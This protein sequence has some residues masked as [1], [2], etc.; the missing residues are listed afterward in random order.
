MTIGILSFLFLSFSTVLCGADDRFSESGYM[1]YPQYGTPFA[2]YSLNNPEYFYDLPSRGFYKS[3][4]TPRFS[5]VNFF[6]AKMIEKRDSFPWSVPNPVEEDWFEEVGGM[7]YEL[8]EGEFRHV[9]EIRRDLVVDLLPKVAE[10]LLK[11][12]RT[13]RKLDQISRKIASYCTVQYLKTE[14]ERSAFYLPGE[15]SHRS[16]RFLEESQPLF[17]KVSSDLGSSDIKDLYGTSLTI[18]PFNDVNSNPLEVAIEV[19]SFYMTTMTRFRYEPSEDRLTLSLTDSRIDRLLNCRAA[20]EYASE[21]DETFGVFRLY[22][23]F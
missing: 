20:L 18:R 16:R 6:A 11:R 2:S 10:D 21:P 7:Q 8:F 12:T 22:F 17:G 15:P 1:G 19:N 13:G 5:W 23:N 4:L 14:D 3:A 9:D